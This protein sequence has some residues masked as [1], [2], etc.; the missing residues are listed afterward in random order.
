MTDPNG[1]LHKFSNDHNNFGIDH[2][3]CYKELTEKS[4]IYD[5]QVEDVKIFSL[6]F[7]VSFYKIEK[8]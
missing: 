4:K 7:L 2:K 1:G 6:I 5:Y 8:Y 3:S